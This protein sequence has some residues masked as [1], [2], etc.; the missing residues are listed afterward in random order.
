MAWTQMKYRHDVRN[1]WCVTDTIADK[2]LFFV[3]LK[4]FTKHELVLYLE[5][6]HAAKPV[7]ALVQK[8]KMPTTESLGYGAVKPA[9][10]RLFHVP[11]SSRFLDRLADLLGSHE[12]FVDQVALYTGTDIVLAFWDAFMPRS[13]IDISKALGIHSARQFCNTLGVSLKES[14]EVYPELYEA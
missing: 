4:S 1:C 11:M 13:T 2:P 9:R 10:D 3:A 14:G 8:H 6:M 7:C 5:S 12:F